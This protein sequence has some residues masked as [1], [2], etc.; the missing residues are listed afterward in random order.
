MESCI[1][2]L[3]CM[4]EPTV[5]A[6]TNTEQPLRLREFLL[7]DQKTLLER[8]KLR[9]S[10]QHTGTDLARLYFALL[11]EQLLSRCDVTTFHRLLTNEM[12]DCD[13]KSVRNLQ[14]AIKK[15]NDSTNKRKI[16]KLRYGT[17][18]H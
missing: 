12:P 3:R 2:K 1:E 4:D 6:P 8:I 18:I 14:I 9:V 7:G 11:G 16:K 15:L 5:E 13:L 17:D 10:T